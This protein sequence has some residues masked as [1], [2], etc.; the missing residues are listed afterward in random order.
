[1]VVG[2]LAVDVLVAPRAPARPDADVPA[3]ITTTA[4]GAGANTAAWLAA[5]GVDVTLVARVGDDGPGRA[6]VAGLAAAGVHPVVAVDTDAPTAAVVVL[7]DAHGRTM[8]SDRGAAARLTPADLPPFD[9]A[10]HVH[11]SG[12]VLRDAGSRAAGVAALVAARAAGATMSLDPQA[13]GAVTRELLHPVA[14]VDLLLPN[15][16][17]LAALTGTPTPVRE[18]DSPGCR[19]IAVPHSA[20]D[21]LD[22]AGAVVVTHGATGA[23]WVD[24]SGRWTGRPPAVAVVDATGAGD[25]FDAGLL[26]AWVRG[27]APEDALAAGCAAGAAAV[28]RRGARPG[29]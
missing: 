24:R 8:F 28:S 20:T 4:G 22:L 16:D 12:Y 6:A 14:P 21:L 25:A 26:A 9:G 10:D 1:M 7:L 11:L 5:L 3:R 29:P 19:G 2:D 15:A 23:T 27:A 18:R 13:T 17:E